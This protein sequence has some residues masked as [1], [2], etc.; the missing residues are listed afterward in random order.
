[1][2]KNATPLLFP[3]PTP[4]SDKGRKRRLIALPTPTHPPR[5]E[6]ERRGARQL[7]LALE[8]PWLPL[9][10]FAGAQAPDRP[11]AVSENHH[12]ITRV[13]ARNRAAR[14]AGIRDGMRLNAAYA[15]VP[16]LRVQPREPTAERAALERLAAWAGRFTPQV[17]LAP[18]SSLLLEV[19]GSER[20][21]GGLEAIAR[22]VRRGT[23]E[24]GYRPRIAVAPT[25]NGALL[26]ARAG[27]MRLI[28]GRDELRRA[29]MGLSLERLE[30]PRADL[31]RLHRLGLKR[32]GELLRM[33]RDGV[34]QRYGAELLERLD[35]TLGRRPDP[36]EPFQPPERYHG[37]LILP[38]EAESHDQLLTAAR[39]LLL[40][41]SGF[42]EARGLAVQ[43]MEL[44]LLHRENP[45]SRLTL[46]LASPGRDSERLTA[47]LAERLEHFELP[48][49]ALAI[50]LESGPLHPLGSLN[51][52][53]FTDPNTS[54]QGNGA[55]LERLTARLGEKALHGLA[56]VADHRPERSW[57]PSPPNHQGAALPSR[58]RPLWLLAH[59]SPLPLIEGRAHYGGPLR[60]LRGPERIESGW[61]ADERVTRDYFAAENPAGVRLWVF[62]E[63]RRSERWFLHGRFG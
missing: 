35:R 24:L 3:E 33:P 48:A 10:L 42:L 43:A 54:P 19:A 52:T 7:W 8:L 49:P 18:P 13:V 9:E 14:A 29:L 1:M 12:G 23:A 46:G 59:P 55:L 25:P 2:L 20:L 32:L 40:E 39:R 58:D 30:L 57:R 11:F 51:G 6:E 37:R 28:R 5:A 44:S 15:L 41:A 34:A 21:F 61:W 26:L 60:L 62:R 27:E 56:M 47:L 63:L 50:A 17:V 22:R 38:M 16:T 36:R 45:T 31:E 4:S 53:L